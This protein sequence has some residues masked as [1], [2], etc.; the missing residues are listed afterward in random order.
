M[1]GDL[2]RLGAVDLRVPRHHLDLLGQRHLRG[3]GGGGG[4]GRSAGAGAGWGGPVVGVCQRG[5]H[6]G[7]EGVP[8]AGEEVAVDAQG[9]EDALLAGLQHRFL[10]GHSAGRGSPPAGHPPPTAHSTPRAPRAPPDEAMV[11]RMRASSRA[12]CSSEYCSFSVTEARMSCTE[13]ERRL[14]M[15][16]YEWSG[17][18]TRQKTGERGGGPSGPPWTTPPPPR[19]SPETRRGKLRHG[20]GTAPCGRQRAR[21]GTLA[22]SARPGT[23]GWSLTLVGAPEGHPRLQARVDAAEVPE[24]RLHL[25]VRGGRLV[26]HPAAPARGQGGGSGTRG[27]CALHPAGVRCRRPRRLLARHPR[28][29]NELTTPPAPTHPQG[30]QLLVPPGDPL[31]P[32]VPPTPPEHPDP[33]PAHLSST[34]STSWCSLRISSSRSW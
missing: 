2:L 14:R 3:G 5:A 20:A 1:V 31:E 8:G 26:G 24:E 27:R 21:E 6:Q 7:V 32:R 30:L 4:E 23:R 28:A 29:A 17:M 10:C 19:T 34:V 11:T 15:V 13:A 9:G 25:L 12:L 33:L 22:P 18:Y 16:T